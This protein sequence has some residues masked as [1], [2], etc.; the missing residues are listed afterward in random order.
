MTYP[1]SL[2]LASWCEDG[3]GGDDGD[4]ETEAGDST[5]SE[6]HGTLALPLDIDARVRLVLFSSSLLSVQLSSS[7]LLST[8]IPLF[9]GICALLSVWPS[10]SLPPPTPPPP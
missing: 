10:L 2:G 5:C 8:V 9:P 6:Q 3:V 7:F 1:G 4:E